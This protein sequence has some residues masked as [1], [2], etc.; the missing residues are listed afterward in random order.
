MNENQIQIVSTFVHN[1]V[2]F[3]LDSEGKYWIITPVSP[4]PPS[5]PVNHEETT[6][7]AKVSGILKKLGIPQHI[8]GFNYIITAVSLIVSDPKYRQRITKILNPKIAAIHNSTPCRVERAIRHAIEHCDT[9]D[10]YFELFG[11]QESLTSKQFVITLA[12]QFTN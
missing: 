4:L 10:L 2:T 8:L 9:N 5:L 11:T 1:D 3:G 6:L 12:N 7:K